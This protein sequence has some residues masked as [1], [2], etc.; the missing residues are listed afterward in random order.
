MRAMM[1]ISFDNCGS[2]PDETNTLCGKDTW[3]TSYSVSV[4]MCVYECV[5]LIYC[6]IEM[7]T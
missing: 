2:Y 5:A 6:K 4:C 7:I 1:N 3:Y